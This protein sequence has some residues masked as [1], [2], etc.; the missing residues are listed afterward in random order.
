MKKSPLLLKNMNNDTKQK[1]TVSLAL[2]AMMVIFTVASPYFLKVDNIMT[3]ALQ[4]A[5]TSITGYGLTFVL[6]SSAVDLSVGSNIAFTGV[7][8]AMLIQAHVPLWLVIPITLLI[9]GCVGTLNAIMVAKMQMPPFIATLGA[10]M[11][12]RGLSMAITN[13]KPVYV[14]V[15]PNFKQLAQYRLF[16]VIPLPVVYMLILAVIASFL[17]K[18]TVIGRNVYAVGSNEE[19]AK[20]SGINIVKIRVFAYMF[21]GIMAAVA[22]IIMTSRV[23]SGQP[24]I[25]V[26]YEANAVAAAVIG[27]TSMRGGHGSISGTILGAFI[28]GVLMNGLNLMNISQNWQMFATGIV[29]IFAVYFDKLRSMRDA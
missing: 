23:N 6:I 24:S 3:I 16:G 7:M 21:S 26:G 22:G 2:I 18:K 28:L 13:A 10:Q 25:A 12:L 29:V 1:L 11:A 27:G 15:L 19:A 14:E 5:I 17:L 4:T 20:L 9:G 8:C